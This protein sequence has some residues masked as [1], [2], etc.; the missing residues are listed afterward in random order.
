MPQSMGNN[1]SRAD[2]DQY[3]W[4]M[5]SLTRLLGRL[6]VG[7]KLCISK[8]ANIVLLNA[9]FVD[10]FKPLLDSKYK[11]SVKS[12]QMINGVTF[13]KGCP[14]TKEHAEKVKQFTNQNHSLSDALKKAGFKDC[15]QSHE[16]LKII[17]CY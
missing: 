16:N 8:A 5:L 15:K 10:P 1:L 9:K 17:D 2:G 12:N 7:S 6:T 13:I 3:S 4:K 14:L 11:E